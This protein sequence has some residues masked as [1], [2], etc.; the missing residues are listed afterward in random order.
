VVSRTASSSLTLVNPVRLITYSSLQ[1][2]FS[3]WIGEPVQHGLGI[4]FPTCLA[5]L[6]E[7]I[8]ILIVT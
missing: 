3:G 8:L 6:P 2:A 4:R 5:L 1:Y 7:C